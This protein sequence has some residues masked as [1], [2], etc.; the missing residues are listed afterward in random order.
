[1]AQKLYPEKRTC[2]TCGEEKDINLF[3]KDSD[4]N[5]Y[6]FKCKECTRKYARAW[7]FNIS[8]EK[9]EELENE[10]HCK[11]CN[12]EI[13]GQKNIDHNHYTG[14][15]RDVLCSNCNA[16]IGMVKENTDILA[17]MIKY[18]EKWENKN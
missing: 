18:I 7:R 15:I 6:R 13:I 11:I 5:G 3:K 8:I 1:M 14:Q 10:T 9:L 4:K 12:E 16:A 17:N 2:L